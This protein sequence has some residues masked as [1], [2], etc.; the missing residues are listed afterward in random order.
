MS[1]NIY[2]DEAFHRGYSTLPRS[3]EGLDG[4]P[5]WADMRAMLPDLAGQAVMDLGCGFGAFARWAA[6]QGAARVLALDLSER[7]LA[8][9]RASTASENVQFVRGDM[10]DAPL[11][12]Q[13]F[14]VIYSSLAI[15]YVDDLQRLFQR[16][17]HVA[18][19]GARLVLSVEHP[20]FSAP[21]SP[22]WETRADGRK[23][24]PLDSYLLE[25]WR[26]TN[27]FV[28]GVRKYHRG[29]GAYVNA[30][31]A[32]GFRLDRL[33]EWAPGPAQL[34]EHPEWLDELHRPTFL[35]L[36]ASAV[37]GGARGRTK[38]T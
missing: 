4:A 20:L 7:M 35:L 1:Q 33:V 15:H 32:S 12:E 14:D 9:A 28:P 19:E 29:I 34:A 18:A 26:E 30:L 24:W 25:G 8:R 22:A 36:S 10:L 31:V 27:W 21:S 38:D 6:E 16:L 13:P 3:R 37:P 5:E 23:V 11:G 17:R 2:D